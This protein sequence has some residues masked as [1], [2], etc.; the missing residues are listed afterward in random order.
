MGAA[1]E[2]VLDLSEIGAGMVLQAP[3]RFIH[4]LFAAHRSGSYA[5][6]MRVHPAGSLPTGAMLHTPLVRWG[7]TVWTDLLT[8]SG[9]TPRITR[10]PYT[11]Q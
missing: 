9:S 6:T 2:G 1:S 4:L 8:G 10:R 7:S 3:T 5:R 11:A